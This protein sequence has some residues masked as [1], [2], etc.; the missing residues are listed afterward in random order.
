[1]NKSNLNRLSERWNG[2]G[3]TKDDV[4]LLH[5]DIR[6]LLLD[7]KK[8][9]AKLDIK[10]II[11]SFLNCIGPGGTLIMPLFNFGFA[12]GETFNINTT[13]SKMGILTEFFRKNYKIIRTGHPMYSFGVIG[14]KHKAF[15]NLD[16][17]SG[18]ANDSPFGLLKKLNGKIAILDLDDQNSMTFIHHVEEINN[19]EYRYFKKF[20]GNY[21]D[22]KSNNKKKTYSLFVRNIELGIKT[23]V[24]PAG[25][26]LW[27]E[28]LYKGDRPFKGSGLRTI[29]SN[30]LFDFISHIIK[31]GKAENI[32]YKK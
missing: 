25:E 8:D 19:V 22:E 20:S 4:V 31:S 5:S 14:K 16:N 17:Y 27:K 11:D 30:D 23:H 9:G 6:R 15:L 21:I 28:R 10:L 3:L 32:L 13:P 24:N 7:L 18:Y 1:M 12:M 26:L 2:S 29:K